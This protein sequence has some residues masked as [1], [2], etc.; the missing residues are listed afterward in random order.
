MPSPAG[1][2]YLTVNGL[3]GFLQQGEISVP[4]LHDAPFINLILCEGSHTRLQLDRIQYPP[5]PRLRTHEAL[6]C[7]YSFFTRTADPTCAVSG[8][9]F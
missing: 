9:S 7:Q 3:V 1:P 4:H 2:H 6:H 8:C 5:R